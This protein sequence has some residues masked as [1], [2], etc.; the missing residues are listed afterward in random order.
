MDLKK[1]ILLILAGTMLTGGCAAPTGTDQ[2][3]DWDAHRAA[4][5]EFWGEQNDIAETPAE[6]FLYYF[7]EG[8]GNAVITQY[9]G[10]DYEVKVPEYIDGHLVTE[11][12]LRYC[13]KYIKALI[14]PDTVE[15][16]RI[17]RHEDIVSQYY[18]TNVTHQMHLS[19]FYVSERNGI[20]VNDYTGQSQVVRIPSEL[21]DPLNVHNRYTVK[22]VELRS[23]E[24]DI[25]LLIVPDCV[26]FISAERYE[27]IIV[28]AEQLSED[29]KANIEKHRGQYAGI[30]V[31]KMNIPAAY[32]WGEN[33]TFAGSTL[34]SVF[35]PQTVTR[36][37]SS[38]FSRSPLLTEVVMQADDLVIENHAFYECA[39]LEDIDISRAVE[40][41]DWAFGKCSGLSDI[42]FGEGLKSIG[43]YSFDG[44]TALGEM[45]IPESVV[46]IEDTAFNERA[47]G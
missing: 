15:D 35:V 36:V 38:A 18:G 34:R 31:E 26:E 46:S 7:D 10:D 8:T 39:L 23:C 12:D 21:E 2:A 29:I 14:L 1:A 13:Y 24:R 42:T 19:F 32:K 25:R 30:G 6:D 45:S 22:K 44:C 9:I 40:I 37:K 47:V 20:T 11:V 28:S 43:A 17:V 16:V 33:R 3:I 41:G 5:E 27:D 4:L